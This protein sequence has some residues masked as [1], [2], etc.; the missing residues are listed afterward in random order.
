MVSSRAATHPH[1]PGNGAAPLFTTGCTPSTALH[2]ARPQ[3]P[4]PGEGE[5]VTRRSTRR[6]SGRPPFPGVLPAVRRGRR[7]AGS[8]ARVSTV[9]NRIDACRFVQIL[10]APVP[11]MGDQVLELLQKIVKASLVEP[12][13]VIAVPKV[14]LDRSPQRSAV[15]RTQMSEQL[16]E[17]PTEPGYALAVLASKFYSRRELRGFLSG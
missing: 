11:Q 8:A 6:R 3:P 12:V 9:E 15:R 2:G 5:R 13:Q 17:V 4:G 10:D 14:S 7:R 16:V 1:G